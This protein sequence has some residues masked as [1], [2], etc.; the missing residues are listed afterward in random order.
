M[1]DPVTHFFTRDGDA[2]VP[3]GLGLSPWDAKSQN[4]IS[5]AGLA[6]HTLEN[7][8]PQVPMVTAKLTLDIFG[9]VPMIALEPHVRVLRDGPR[10]QIVETE[11]HGAGKV[12]IRATALRVRL[13]ESP[14]RTTPL[15]HPMPPADSPQHTVSWFEMHRIKG[16][17][18]GAS[19]AGAMWGRIIA[20]I[21]PGVPLTPTERM[22]MTADFG[23]GFAPLVDHRH[24]TSAN[25][26]IALHMTR[27]P[28]GD[29][30]LI[31]ATS[32]SAGNGIGVATAQIGDAEGM[33]ATAVQTVFLAR[34]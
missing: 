2:Y 34:R 32:H 8:A 29:W 14:A 5:L 13:G 12:W 26:D 9:S 21:V 7:I 6:A 20:S 3:S 1:T 31:D 22:A 33:F 24:W 27:L 25:L 4:G 16:N 17:F 30:L 10:F 11:L 28:L 23:S 15:T 18:L 19:G